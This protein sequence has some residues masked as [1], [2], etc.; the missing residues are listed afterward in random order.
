MSWMKECKGINLDKVEQKAFS[1]CF[2]W[3]HGRQTQQIA[4]LAVF[5]RKKVQRARRDL[6]PRSPA[7]K[8][9]AL[10]LS[11]LR[12]HQSYSLETIKSIPK[13]LQW[14][15]V[16]LNYLRFLKC[17]RLSFCMTY[18]NQAIIERNVFHKRYLNIIL[19]KRALTLD[20]VV[21]RG[22]RSM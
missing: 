17:A 7:P 14:F 16:S 11:G 4:P 2:G 12:A 13:T 18:S 6:N 1:C 21:H 19:L 8:A 5:F 22:G 3:R 20:D 9:D 15:R 10:I